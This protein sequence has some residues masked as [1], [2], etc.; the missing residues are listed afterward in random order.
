M[1]IFKVM[2]VSEKIVPL[3]AF[4]LSIVLLFELGFPSAED[5]SS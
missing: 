2:D 3:I 5:E 4:L 1:I